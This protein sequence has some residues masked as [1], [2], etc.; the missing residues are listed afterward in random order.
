MGGVFESAEFQWVWRAAILAILGGLGGAISR[1]VYGVR[2]LINGQK[3]ALLE[4]L[5][6]AAVL[7]RE[8]EFKIRDLEFKIR[9]LE[10][11]MRTMRDAA[12]LAVILPKKEST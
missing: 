2:I 10:Q 6:M 5:S 7:N 12:T 11:V 3:D 9:E 1:Q 8:L 4:A